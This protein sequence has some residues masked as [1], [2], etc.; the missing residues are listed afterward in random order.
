MW[1]SKQVRL[2]YG[3]KFRTVVFS[4]DGGRGIREVSEVKIYQDVFLTEKW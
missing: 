2:I 3:G 1:N 4:G